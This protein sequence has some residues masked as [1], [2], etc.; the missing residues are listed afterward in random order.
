MGMDA[1]VHI[2]VGV[3]GEDCKISDVAKKLPP[4][5]LDPEDGGVPCSV[6]DEE[7]GLEGYGFLMQPIRC[8]EETVGLGV[9]V[10]C[11][12]WD[13]GVV[14]FDFGSLKLE[15]EQAMNSL[16]AVFEKSGITA[17][18]GVWCQTEFC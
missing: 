16:R 9:S 4:G 3:R 2:W 17:P 10:F 7:I 6:E 8:Q 1:R 15:A 14:G 13:Y 12:D 5:M 18:I 11:H